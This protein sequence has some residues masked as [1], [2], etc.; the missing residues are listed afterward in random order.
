MYHNDLS[1]TDL[2]ILLNWTTKTN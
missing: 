2:I 1:F